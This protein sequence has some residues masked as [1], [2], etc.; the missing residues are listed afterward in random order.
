MKHRILVRWTRL[1]LA[2]PTPCIRCSKRDNTVMEHKVL[3]PSGA[4]LIA[5]YHPLC[6]TSKYAERIHAGDMVRE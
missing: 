3:T 2:E 6:F 5:P 4:Y 1:R